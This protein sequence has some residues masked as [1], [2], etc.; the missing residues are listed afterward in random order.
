MAFH[1]LR[2]D[3]VIVA[4]WKR[5][6]GTIGTKSRHPDTNEYWKDGD[7][8]D[9]WGE[10]MEDLEARGIAPDYSRKRK[11]KPEPEPEPEGGDDGITV[12][13]WFAQWWTSIDVGLKSNDNYAYIFRAHVLPEWGH[14]PLKDITASKVNAWEQRMIDAGYARDGVPSSARTRLSTLLGDAV[15]EGLIGSNP[16]LR[17]RHRGRR[18][19]VGTGGRGQETY[20]I[21]PFEMVALAERMAIAS[22]RDQ[23]FVFGM[24]LGFTGMRW[25]E[26]VGLQR[27]YVKLGKLRVDWQLLEHRGKLYLLPPKDDS[28]RDIDIPPFLQDLLARQIAAHPEQRCTCEPVAIPDQKEQPCQGGGAFVFLTPNGGH[29]R[30]S[31]Y[32]RRV[33][34]PAA[35]G[36]YT[37]AKKDA[38]RVPVLVELDSSW[39][40]RPVPAWPRA[41]PGRPWQRPAANAYRGRPLG[42]GV[43]SGSVRRDLVEYAIDAGM[44]EAEARAM[45]RQQLIDRLVRPH[46]VGEDTTVAS[47]L[48]INEGM[49]PHDLRH[50]HSTLIHGQTPP[51]LRDD[52]MGHVSPDM[53][54]MRGRYTDILPQWRA[55]LRGFLQ[56]VWEEA[57]AERAWFGERSPVGVVDELLAPFRDGRAEPVAPFERRA[58]LLQFP[59]RLTG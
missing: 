10:W 21:S 42:I 13:E 26:A 59:T 22:G 40:G 27:R 47:W 11:K 23:D 51:K 24:L 12:N 19:G 57:L 25:A 31:N 1:Q 18:S 15:T 35:D 38:V 37:A 52:R 8:A 50:W 44:S 2:P 5:A 4:R 46:R 39:P 58:Q 16:A 29:P 33:F 6:D 43:N 7:E 28:N 53:R 14:W 48:P 49:S 17:Q 20:V 36:Q 45:T 9:A 41:T 30:N 3:G 55:D 54:G 34:D 56:G 32:A